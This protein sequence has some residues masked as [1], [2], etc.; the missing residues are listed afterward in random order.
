MPVKEIN[1]ATS[2]SFDFWIFFE[3]LFDLFFANRWNIDKLHVREVD[4]GNMTS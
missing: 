1:R 4:F 2:N 3:K